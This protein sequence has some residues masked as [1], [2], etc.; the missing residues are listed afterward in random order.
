M[1][2]FEIEFGGEIYEIEAPDEQSAM[3]ALAEEIGEE[4]AASMVP[5]PADF[6]QAPVPRENVFGD[7]TSEAMEQPL[8]ALPFYRQRAADPDQLAW[9]LARAAHDRAEHAPGTDEEEQRHPG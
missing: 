2:T 4:S 3:N 8:E 6:G 1:E 5:S 9:F 7:V